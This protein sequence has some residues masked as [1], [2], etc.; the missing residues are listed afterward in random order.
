MLITRKKFYGVMSI[1]LF[2]FIM[3]YGVFGET[4]GVENGQRYGRLL[5]RNVIT[6]DGNGT[7]AKGPFDIIIAGN[8]I[9]NI[10]FTSEKEDT[11]ARESHI[12]D[13]RGKYLLPGLINIHAHIHD[14]RAGRPIPFEYLYK[15]WLACGVT[16]VRDVG[17]NNAKTLIERQKS[18]AGTIAAPRIF[19]YM[20]AWERTAEAMRK[21]IQEIK[22]QGGDGVKIF[23]LDQDI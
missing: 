12:I 15:L 5:I 18:A 21:R 19:L 6:I 11:Y 1:I 17:S 16:T 23:G 14:E 9:E 8:K 10:R 22:K 3:V 7:P 13:G 4:R 20:V 2:C